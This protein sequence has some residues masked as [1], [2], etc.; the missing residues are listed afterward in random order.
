LDN[1]FDSSLYIHPTK[2][3]GRKSLISIAPAFLGIRAMK[4][5]FEGELE[6]MMIDVVASF[7]P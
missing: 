4:E 6:G 5:D 1:T 3:I 7:C 2:L